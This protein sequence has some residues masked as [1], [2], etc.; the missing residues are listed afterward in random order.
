MNEELLKELKNVYTKDDLE[1]LEK[2]EQILYFDTLNDYE[3]LN[4]G[5][6]LSSILFEWN[7]QASI[8]II[9]ESDELA[10][11]QFVTNKKAQR[12]IDFAMKKRRCV[13]QTGHSSFWALVKQVVDHDQ[14]ELLKKGDILPFAGAFPLYVAAEH[15]Y[16][17]CVSGMHE[18]KD[19]H[20]V[21]KGLCE[22]LE[23]EVPCFKKTIY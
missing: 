1:I 13:K 5:N 4:I 15:K 23:I 2:I 16:T 19:F 14:E 12:N 8:S 22:Y 17:I 6:L 3:L 18:G 7:E 21:V 10:V 11:Y 9:R 20:I